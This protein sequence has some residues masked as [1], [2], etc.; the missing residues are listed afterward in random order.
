MYLDWGIS[1]NTYQAVSVTMLRILKLCT[2]Q[3]NAEAP[4]Q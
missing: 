2:Y 3:I 4:V 1:E